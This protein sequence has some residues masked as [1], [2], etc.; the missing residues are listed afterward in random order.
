MHSRNTV[1]TI[2][3]Q[4]NPVAQ[5]TRFADVTLWR[6]VL[7]WIIYTH[8][9]QMLKKFRYNFY[10][11]STLR[12]KLTGFQLTKKF[13]AFYG[14]PNVHYSI[15]QCQPPVPILSQLDPVHG[16]TSHFLK[17]H[18]NIILTS[19]SGSTKRSFPSGFPTKIPYTPLLSPIRATC[20][21]HFI[22]LDVISR[23]TL[24]EQYR[25]LSVP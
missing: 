12:Q 7:T 3:T 14:T 20:P 6:L 4:S 24:G 17:I 2:Q 15:H 13:P 22:L 21:A 9:G 23:T 16:P 18:L 11:Y 19:Q 25:S 1:Q 8:L 5:L 10:T